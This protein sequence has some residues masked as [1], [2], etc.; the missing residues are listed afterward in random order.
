[1]NCGLP[2][3]AFYQDT[4]LFTHPNVKQLWQFFRSPFPFDISYPKAW[5]RAMAVSVFVSLFL[6]IFQPFGLSTLEGPHRLLL[7]ASF[8]LPC[9]P[10]VLLQGL[11]FAWLSKRYD[12]EAHW[13]V[14]HQV[15]ATLIIPLLIAISNYFH[16][17]WLFQWPLDWVI[18]GRMLF[19]TLAVS[20]FPILGLVYWDWQKL[21]AR[22]GKLAALV[23]SNTESGIPAR[24]S[25]TENGNSSDIELCGENQQE[26][27][28]VNL[29]DLLYAKAEANYVEICLLKDDRLQHELIRA[30]LKSVEMQLSKWN[31]NVVRCHRSYL[32]NRLK[33]LKAEGNAQGLLLSLKGSATVPVSR[34]YVDIFRD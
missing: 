25:T 23:S 17:R 2:K 7:I 31:Q 1:M 18:F 16:A 13:K 26:S 29:E 10:V 27:I 15:L 9:F 33:I 5:Y 12:C 21:S 24:V 22:F 3:T 6:C 8:G 32:V 19:H 34:R 28:R 11:S 4:P 20:F 14:Y 30:P